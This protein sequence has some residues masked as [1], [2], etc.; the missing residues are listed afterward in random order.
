VT[1]KIY[2]LGGVLGPEVHGKDEVGCVDVTV[3]EKGLRQ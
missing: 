2:F 3:V 1:N